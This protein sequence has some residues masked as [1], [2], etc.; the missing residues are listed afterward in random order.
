M[1]KYRV[2]MIEEGASSIEFTY[3]GHQFHIFID[4]EREDGCLYCVGTHLETGGTVV[5]GWL[6]TDIYEWDDAIEWAL[7]SA[8][9]V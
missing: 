8:M 6:P 7:K 2:K 4:D 3:K 9:L 1:A 5:D